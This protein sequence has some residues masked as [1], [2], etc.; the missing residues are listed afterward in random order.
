MSELVDVDDWPKRRTLTV[1]WSGLGLL[2]DRRGRYTVHLWEYVEH[3]GDNC[4]CKHT[5]HYRYQTGGE[6]VHRKALPDDI[7][8]LPLCRDNYQ[9]P[10][11]ECPRCHR[12]DY[13]EQ[14]HWAPYHLFG[15][16]ADNWPTGWLCKSCHTEWH[17]IVTPN[18][19][20]TGRTNG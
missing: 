17:R 12:I 4:W 13:L 10:S 11:E 14:H 18:M 2:R 7:E 19:H 16:D 1:T 6:H 8:W 3:P 9:P 20:L 5:G 15:Q